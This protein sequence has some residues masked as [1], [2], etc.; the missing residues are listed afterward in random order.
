[1]RVVLELRPSSYIDNL[2]DLWV[3]KAN[4]L[5]NSFKT[6]SYVIEMNSDLIFEE[7]EKR[8]S[9]SQNAKKDNSAIIERVQELSAKG[10]S[11]RKIEEELKST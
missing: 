6:K 4:F 11:I 2:K 7:T 8:N 5:D 1:M 9:K 10:L 3:L